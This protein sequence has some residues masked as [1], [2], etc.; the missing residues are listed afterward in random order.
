MKTGKTLMQLAQELEARKAAKKDY[1]AD[2]R[3]LTAI[4]V[5]A[6]EQEFATPMLHM[7]GVAECFGIGATAHDQLASRLGIPAKYY[8]KMVADAPDLWAYNV[9]HW[10]NAQPARRMVRTMNGTVRAFLSDRYRPL[11]NEDLAEVILPVMQ[12]LDLMILSCEITE[13]RM[14]IKAVDA[15]ITKDVPTGRK[16]G[17]GSHVFF[18]TMSPAITIS[19]SEIG[20]GS[21]SIETAVWTHL[22]TNLAVIGQKSM[23]KYHVGARAEVSDEVY[24]LLTDG[25]KRLTDAATWSQ[26]RDVVSAAFN[27]D[28]FN[29]TVEMIGET[30]T[31]KMEG[32]P[33]K[34]IEILGDRLTLSQDERT[35]VLKHLIQGGD[36]SQYG[37]FNAV[38]RTAE[39]IV[40]YD[41]A[42]EFEKMGGTVIEMAKNDWMELANAA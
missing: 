28:A 36:L 7:P 26:V 17:D 3:Q 23:K 15:R 35:S 9:N 12:K 37:L 32:D 4:T 40:S 13:R 31:R 6:D 11:E 41:R 22:C 14:Y 8:D 16:M 5:S 33:V 2:T 29:S 1:I 30:S 42:T 25:T 24:A 38:T 21:L 27:P 34:A 39:D 18:D 20:L 19:N 10:L